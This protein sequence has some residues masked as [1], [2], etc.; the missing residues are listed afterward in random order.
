MFCD[1][2][3]LFCDLFD[4]FRDSF[5]WFVF[6]GLWC[7]VIICNCFVTQLILLWFLFDV[8]VF[9]LCFLCFF[10]IDCDAFVFFCDFLVFYVLLWFVCDC[11][12]NC[13]DL[14]WCLMPQWASLR[15][16]ELKVQFLVNVYLKSDGFCYKWGVYFKRALAI[17][18]WAWDSKIKGSISPQRLF[19]KWRFLSFVEGGT[20]KQLLRSPGT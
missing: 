17:L 3:W 13:C 2:L 9:F 8:V 15:S 5:L 10:V 7:L 16:P 4:V 12:V 19:K 11:F 1:V 6:G 18:G 20:W 14:L